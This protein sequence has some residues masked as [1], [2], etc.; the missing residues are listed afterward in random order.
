VQQWNVINDRS[1]AVGST[2]G[3]FLVRTTV[4]CPHAG[5]GATLRFRPSQRDLTAGAGAICGGVNEQLL[6]PDGPPCPLQSVQAIDKDDFD[7]LAKS[8][9]AHGPA[10]SRAT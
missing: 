1:I 7:H 8:A 5:A 2:S 10:A 6:R 4:D 9:H 3:H